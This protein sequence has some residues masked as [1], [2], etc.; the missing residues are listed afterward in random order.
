MSVNEQPDLQCIIVEQAPDAILFA[1]G[2][3]IIRL[4]NRGAERIFGVA[5]AEAIGQSLDL[6][7]PE[8][9]RQRHWDGWHKVVQTGESRYSKELLRVPAIRHD[10]NQFSSEFSIVMIKD[11]CGKVQ[12]FAAILRDVTAQWERE[13]ELKAKLQELTR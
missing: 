12:G 5:A 3:G 7:I 2:G 8:K 6:I 9:L 1:D 11:E 10:G 4:W 13:R